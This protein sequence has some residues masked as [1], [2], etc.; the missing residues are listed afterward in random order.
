MDPPLEPKLFVIVFY[1]CIWNS[2]KDTVYRNTV[3]LPRI[4]NDRGLSL[5][6]VLFTE[7]TIGKYLKNVQIVDWERGMMQGMR[8]ISYFKAF[9]PPKSE[10]FDISLPPDKPGWKSLKYFTIYN[11]MLESA[12]ESSNEVRKEIFKI[13][14]RVTTHFPRFQLSDGS[15]KLFLPAP[16]STEEQRD[17][18]YNPNIQRPFRPLDMR[19]FPDYNEF[20]YSDM[21]FDSFFQLEAKVK[22]QGYRKK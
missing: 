3:P 2:L 14:L 9:F 17:R 18:K 13:F 1:H 15:G 4:S 16:L 11:H 21:V 10:S 5:E 19:R 8:T 7:E 12:G 20:E 6:S 22:P